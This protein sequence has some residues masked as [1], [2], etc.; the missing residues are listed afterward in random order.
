M[1]IIEPTFFLRNIPLFAIISM[2]MMGVS[3][4]S[5]EDYLQIEQN[6]ITQQTDSTDYDKN[7]NDSDSISINNENKESSETPETSVVYM[8]SIIVAHW[9]I[10]HF[11]NGKSDDTTIP[12]DSVEN[13]QTRYIGFIS[14]AQADILGVCEYS[15]YFSTDGGDPRS[16]IF[17]MYDYASI[18][19]K[20]LYNC[21]SIFTKHIPFYNER[22]KVFKRRVQHRY[23]QA[24]DMVINNDT[25]KFIE[26]HLDWNEGTM[27]ATCRDYQIQSLIN[28]YQDFKYVIICADFNISKE[29]E[30]DVFKEA[31]FSLA[32]CGDLG[33]FKTA[34]SK[35]PAAVIDNIIVKGFNIK[36]VSTLGDATLSDH[37]L[38]KC[39]L[40]FE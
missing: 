4:C 7:K 34:P 28:E 29:A 20:A 6:T 1:K 18:G 36:N 38:I 3:S 5:D 26:T 32:S 11:S 12:P 13:M 37:C 30:Y 24:I 14:S 39:T 10:G 9:N 27:G 16:L 8:D 21:N 33:Y 19:Y 15:H 17:N 40:Y 35:N 2:I 31:G 25:V 22:Y 23:Y